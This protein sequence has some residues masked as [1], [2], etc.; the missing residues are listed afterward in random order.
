[1]VPGFLVTLIAILRFS[2]S[3]TVLSGKFYR[4]RSAPQVIQYSLPC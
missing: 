4:A 2:Q 1:M 3:A